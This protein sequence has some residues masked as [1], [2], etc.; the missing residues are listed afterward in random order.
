MSEPMSEILCA[1]LKEKPLLISISRDPSF[2]PKINK[3]LCI[4]IS[5]NVKVK[6]EKGF[7]WR[8]VKHAT[9]LGY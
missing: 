1:S 8:E 5:K 3:R 6:E 2:A 9:L 7:L 4:V